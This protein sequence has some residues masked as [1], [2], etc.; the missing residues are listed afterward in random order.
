VHLLWSKTW[1]DPVAFHTAVLSLF[2][3]LLVVVSGLQGW[4]ILR[5]DATAR[6]AANAADRS[7]KA[8][9]ALQLP[10][11]RIKP[12]VLSFGD[13]IAGEVVTW[14][15]DVRSV[16]FSNLGATKAYPIELRYG[17]TVG[18]PL[19][20]K[21]FYSF[22]ETF[23][24]NLIFEPDPSVAPRKQLVGSFKV[25]EADWP[26]ICTGAEDVWFYC[27]LTYEDFMQERHDASFCWKWKS[28]GSGMAWRPD[29]TPAYNR[30]T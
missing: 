28:T 25:E 3:A 20:A 14:H 16:L 15:C 22:A 8:A 26:L 2:T 27:V 7:A 19:P 13:S 30:K 21:P 23:L 10:I 24:P 6:I 18:E 9:I 5:A 29:P 12:D 17:L 11:I 1:E 4:F